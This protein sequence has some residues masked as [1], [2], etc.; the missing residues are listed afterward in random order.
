MGW[1]ITDSKRLEEA[2]SE[3]KLKLAREIGLRQGMIVVEMGGGQGGFTA[4]LAKTVGESG[5]VL[6]IDISTEYLSEFRENLNK[7]HVEHLVTFIQSDAAHLE[8]ILSDN[9][10]DIVASYRFL[11]ELK[12]PQEMTQI[13]KEMTRIVR[14]MGKS[15][16]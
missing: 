6:S 12:Q 5:K 10:A 4:A 8:S 2:I 1:N 11:E 9:A 14:N 16:S 7:H 3:M 15:A 13:V